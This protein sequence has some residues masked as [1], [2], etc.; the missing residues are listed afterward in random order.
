MLYELLGMSRFRLIRLVGHV[1]Y[2]TRFAHLG[3]VRRFV[4]FCLGL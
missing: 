4:R 3:A 2:H 1:E